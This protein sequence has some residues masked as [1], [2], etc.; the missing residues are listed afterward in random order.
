MAFGYGNMLSIQA[1]VV[2]AVVFAILGV[3]WVKGCDF[4]KSR[5]PDVFVRFYLV[6]AVFRTLMVLLVA[7]VYIFFLS[8][9]LAESKA[10]VVMLFVMYSIMMTLTLKM[11]H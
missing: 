7:S 8:G 1:I 11:K 9:S 5:N 4:V 3:G 6:Y 2:C 10:F